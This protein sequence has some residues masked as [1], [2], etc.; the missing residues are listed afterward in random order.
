MADH[1]SRLED[2]SY[3]VKDGNIREIFPDKQLMALSIAKPIW[4]A[5]IVNLLVNGVYPT[6]VTSQ[7]KKKLFFN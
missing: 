7:Q 5:N 1:L 2:R 3:I 4:Y 6:E